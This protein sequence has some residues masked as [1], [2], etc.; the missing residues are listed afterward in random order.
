MRNDRNRWCSKRN[1]TGADGSCVG[2]CTGNID[3]VKQGRHACR[4]GTGRAVL[5]MSHVAAEVHK[6]RSVPSQQDERHAKISMA[7]AG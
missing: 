4:G 2:G 7:P 6:S 3:V 5:R 1:N